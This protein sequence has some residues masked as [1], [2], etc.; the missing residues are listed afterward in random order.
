MQS[1]K[2][3]DTVRVI[4]SQSGGLLHCLL[5]NISNITE[6]SLE[7]EYSNPDSITGKTNLQTIQKADIKDIV[8]R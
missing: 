2:L 4:W 7:I 3:G 8:K 5:G 1:I 6:S